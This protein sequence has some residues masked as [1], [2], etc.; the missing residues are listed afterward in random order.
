MSQ[1]QFFSLTDFPNE[2]PAPCTI[3]GHIRREGSIIHLTYELKGANAVQ[4][5]APTDPDRRFDLW[6]ATCFEWFV[7]VNGAIDYWE[8]NMA[9]SGQWNCFHLEDYRQGLREEGAIAALPFE[10]SRQ[11]EGLTLAL[12]VDLGALI[13][14]DLPI[15]VGIT[16]VVQSLSGELHY[17]ALD[18][19]GDQA[20]F[21]LRESFQI[22]L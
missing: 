3:G 9:P 7:G 16:T 4:I 10:V 20:D 12:T 14:A 19:C 18:H 11:D 6:E 22:C 5:P 15:E 13:A 2:A 21:H 8:F 1:P 17:L